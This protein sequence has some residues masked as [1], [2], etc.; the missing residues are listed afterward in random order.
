MYTCVICKNVVR[1]EENAT[2]LCRG[3]LMGGRAVTHPQTTWGGWGRVLGH[4][5]PFHT[6]PLFVHGR[7]GH[8]HVGVRI[9][10]NKTLLYLPYNRRVSYTSARG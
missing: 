10:M 4:P 3:N 7:P 8:R 2:L 6:P 1:Y 9:H 5:F